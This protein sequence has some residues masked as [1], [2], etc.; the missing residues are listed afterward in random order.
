MRSAPLSPEPK[1]RGSKSHRLAHNAYLFELTKSGAGTSVESQGQRL[2]SSVVLALMHRSTFRPIGD[3]GSPGGRGGE[4]VSGTPAPTNAGIWFCTA[5]PHPATPSTNA[6]SMRSRR[7]P[8]PRDDVSSELPARGPGAS[9]RVAT[10][11][12]VSIDS[13]LYRCRE[14]GLLSDPAAGRAW[15]RL[16]ELRNET[17]F[18]SEPAERYPGD[19]P[20]MLRQAFQLV[21]QETG[22]IDRGLARLLG[23]VNGLR[24]QRRSRI[25]SFVV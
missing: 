1:A 13:L 10:G 9:R 6:R 12:G 19:Q 2:R 23:F 25:L 4:D 8:W 22:L 14:V 20:V 21:T 16:A 24:R 3:L 5:T 11:V 15:R 17:G 7:S 18:A